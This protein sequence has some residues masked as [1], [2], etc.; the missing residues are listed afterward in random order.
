MSDIESELGRGA[1]IA[2]SE[3]S[4]AGSSSLAIVKILN[5]HAGES[6]ELSASIARQRGVLDMR[7]KAKVIASGNAAG[8]EV[9]KDLVKALGPS[10]RPLI[11]DTINGHTWRSRVAFMRGQCLVGISAANRVASGIGEGDLVV[12]DIEPDT[13]PRDLEEPKDLAKALDDDERARAAFDVLPFG[14]KRRHVAA[15][16]EAKTAETRQRGLAKLVTTLRSERPRGA[17]GKKRR[18]GA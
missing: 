9:P 2:A 18:R 16:E 11:A 3:P 5:D 10:A 13:E 17:S 7:F 8:V 4:R 6:G 14:L 1:N 12:V 15:I